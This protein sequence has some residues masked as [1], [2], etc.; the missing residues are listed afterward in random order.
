M[1]L[2]RRP[3]RRLIILSY[4]LLVL[5]EAISLDFDTEQ[6]EVRSSDGK[7]G[8]S[9][10]THPDP[11][12]GVTR[13]AV[14]RKRRKE[15]LYNVDN[16]S[17]AVPKDPRVIWSTDGKE[18]AIFMCD[19]LCGGSGAVRLYDETS[20]RAL[21]WSEA[22]ERMIELILQKYPPRSQKDEEAIRLNTYEWVCKNVSAPS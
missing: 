6:L 22:E 16:D 1:V 2:A 18:A 12:G 13:V 8:I 17:C 14:S 10:W 3:L 7:I 9:F 20:G 4:A 15:W 11:F 21:K 19:V 5:S